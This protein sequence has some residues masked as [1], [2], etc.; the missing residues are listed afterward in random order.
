M[1]LVL[2]GLWVVA[3]GLAGTVWLVRLRY[4]RDSIRQR[5][6][7]TPTSFDGFPDDAPRLSVLVAAKDEEHNIETCIETLLDQ[8]YPNYELIAI[9]DRST[10]RTPELLAQLQAK[11]NGKLRVVT[12]TALRD[13][14]FGKNNAMREGVEIADGEWLLFMD[15]D[16]RQLSRRTLS[17]G[18]HD[19]M[20]HEVGMMSMQPMLDTPTWWEKIIQPVCSLVLMIWF[21]PQKV[22]D[23]N[24]KAAYAT[25]MFMLFS[26]ACYDAIGGH[27]S[28]RTHVNEDIHLARLVKRGGHRLRLTEND[29]LYRVRM[30]T[31]P[32]EASRGWARIFFGSLI[33]VR[34]ITFSAS[35]LFWYTMFPWACFVVALIGTWRA[36][37][38]TALRWQVALGAWAFAIVCMQTFLWRYYTLV[39]TPRLW[40]IT[41]VVGTVAAFGMLMSSLLQAIGWKG[42]TWR[43]TTYHGDR[44][45]R[46]PGGV[47]VELPSETGI[48][49]PAPPDANGTKTVNAE[50]ASR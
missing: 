12:V 23:P 44:V 45:A 32:R 16:C 39:Y 43:G 15:A 3:G 35:S 40:S 49:E 37:A 18:V 5:Q 2:F 47:A 9:D 8:D 38:E 21:V 11:S 46:S 1:H 24:G 31:S 34:R 30:Y 17:I 48:A 6:L 26:R 13:G 4:L 28:V 27:N 14:W 19:A 41:F 29:G 7:L 50:I 22:N 33:T 42:T 20:K 36:S 10:D 25:G